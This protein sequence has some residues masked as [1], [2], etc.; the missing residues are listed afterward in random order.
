MPDVPLPTK[1]IF[2]LTDLQFGWVH[3]HLETEMVQFDAHISYTPN[4]GLADFLRALIV[5]LPYPGAQ[6]H[7]I[8]SHEPGFYEV[9]LSHQ[10]DQRL[11]IHIQEESEKRAFL[12]PIHQLEWLVLC[13][14][15]KLSLIHI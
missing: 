2:T 12:P 1:L 13:D 6:S 8:W 7:C 5:V 14:L 15:W 11:H 9:T 3:A 4:D 10:A